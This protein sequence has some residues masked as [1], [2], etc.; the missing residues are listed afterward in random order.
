ME[1]LDPSTHYELSASL[2]LYTSREGNLM[3][4]WKYHN[5]QPTSVQAPSSQWIARFLQQALKQPTVEFLHPRIIAR[6]PAFTA[7]WRPA[8]PTTMFFTMPALQELSG[9]VFPQPPLLFI[10]RNTTVYVYA[11]PADERPEPDTPLLYAP[12]PNYRAR[13]GWVCWGSGTVPQDADPE[14]WEESFFASA[15]SHAIDGGHT[16]GKNLVTLWKGLPRRKRFP[17]NRLKDAGKTV[18]SA[19]SNVLKE[20]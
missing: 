11:L 14:A 5:G 7:W 9:E 19:I 1:L 8:K 10:R 16:Q 4:Y 3:L 15:F 17:M 13:D 18:A 12:Y 6:G 20:G 2:A